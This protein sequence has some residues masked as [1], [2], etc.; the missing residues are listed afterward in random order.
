M[1]APSDPLFA[2]LEFFISLLGNIPKTRTLS[3]TK[4]KIVM[5]LERKGVVQSRMPETYPSPDDFVFLADKGREI[6][7][8]IAD[9]YSNEAFL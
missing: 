7:S 1:S 6:L 2:E 9:H 4:Q 8:N 3:A 5:N